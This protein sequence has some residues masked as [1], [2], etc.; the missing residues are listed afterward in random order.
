EQVSEAMATSR[1]PKALAALWTAWH[2]LFAASR[3]EFARYVA[4]ANEGAKELGFP[5]TGAMWRAKYDMPPDA[6]AKE[7]DRLWEQVKPLFVSLHAYV[8]WKLREKYG[9]AVPANGPIP[10][11]LLG[12]IWAQQWSNV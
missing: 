8:R 3:P 12:D 2:D 5:D 6:Y 11:H 10:M 7:L 1:D 9:D 4:L